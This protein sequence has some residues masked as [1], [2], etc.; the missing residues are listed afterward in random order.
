VANNDATGFMADSL[1]AWITLAALLLIPFEARVHSPSMRGAFARGMLWGLVLSAGAMTKI[2]FL[3]FVVLIGPTLFI[4]R[5]RQ[6]GIRNACVAL[7]GF[8]VS[9]MPAAAYLLKFGGWSFANGIGASFGRTA[10]VHQVSVVPAELYHVSVVPFL[11]DTFSHA[12]GMVLLL[13]FVLIAPIYLIIKKRP[14]LKEP[15]SLAFL[16]ALVFGVIVLAS[17]NRQVRYAIPV[18]I[19]LPFLLA[20]ILSGKKIAISR[21]SATLTAVLVFC[22][23]TLPAW[24]VRHRAQRQASLARSDAIL[25]QA[26]RCNDAHILLM[27]DSPTLNE[28][29]MDLAWEVT[30]LAQPIQIRSVVYSATFGIPIDEDYRQMRAAD[31]I[32]FQDHDDLSSLMNLQ[33]RLPEYRQYVSELRGYAPRRAYQD[34]TIYSK[35]CVRSDHSGTSEAESKPAGVPGILGRPG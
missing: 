12:P 25:A 34:V 4:I 3:Y 35:P 29:V 22:A 16:I 33:V 32:V 28:N 7:I 15:A 24:S 20:V 1:F 21:T 14:F 8:V 9:S 27:T 11:R 6:S 2:S 17:V 18:I 10:K 23:L 31:L 5:L 19:A 30:S 13:V 26:I